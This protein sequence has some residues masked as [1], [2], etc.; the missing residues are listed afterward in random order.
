MFR[1]II[2]SVLL[3][4]ASVCFLHAQVNQEWVAT[5]GLNG[6][7][8]AVV[9]D[10]AGNIYVTGPLNQDLITNKYDPQGN[11][12]WTASHF[13]PLWSLLEPSNRHIMLDPEGHVYVSIGIAD[14]PTNYDYFT[15]KYNPDGTE[16]W[17]ARFVG[18][19]GGHDYP[20]SM[21]VD[22]NGNVYVTGRSMGNN[23][24]YATVKY[25]TSGNQLWVALYNGSYNHSDYAHDIV[26]DSN[27]DV[28]VTGSVAIASQFDQWA[29]IKYNSAGVEQWIE[30]KGHSGT[31]NSAMAMII[32]D[33]GDVCVTGYLYTPGINYATVK[34]DPDGNELWT[35]Y[36][37]YFGHGDYAF[38]IA[39][40][41]FGNIYVTGESCGFS[42]PDFYRN[43]IATV[44]YDA[45]GNQIWAARYVEPQMIYAKASPRGI[46][47]DN[48]GNV[49]V[50]G[51]NNGPWISD[52]ITLMYT[53]DGEERWRARC[54]DSGQNNAYSIAIDR[55]S[56]VYVAGRGQFGSN[57]L[58]Y[59][60]IKYNQDP[61]PSNRISPLSPPIVIPA[62]GGRFHYLLRVQNP[63]P[64]PTITSSW[65]RL[66]NST[67]NYM[68]VSTT[69]ART[70]PGNAAPSRIFTQAI[71]DTLPAGTYDFISYIGIYPEYIQDSSF[72]TI[73]KSA[74]SDGSPWVSESSCTGDFFDEFALQDNP[75]SIHNSS[76]ITHNCVPNPFNP[77]TTIRFDLPIAAQVTLEVF[78]INGRNVGAHGMRPSGGGGSAGARSAPLQETWYYVGSHEI[79][80]DGSG[81]PSGVYLYRLT[82]GEL[83]ANG[84]IVLLK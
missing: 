84:K 43:D 69:F 60:T 66:R 27:G 35:S 29:T 8:F 31:L 75:S 82:A 76:L 10:S 50:T 68:N 30:Y 64:T 70:L 72:F 7:A 21:A 48:F 63:N 42:T 47:T 62:N 32:D 67:G 45:A 41:R 81:L 83:T 57:L 51:R 55:N 19:A 53:T 4:C 15:I 74:L 28:Y 33:S 49:Y 9:T 36:Y 25:D 40:D 23:Y 73:T 22:N 18:P 16:A 80:F 38:Y 17:E 54:S 52:F 39:G 26:V 1:S 58:S 78:D 56:N 65:N 79:I 2:L 12:L 14:Y 13:G 3:L 11:L 20:N 46:V 77:T 5:D 59:L 34:Y 24:N 61:N 71:A 37:D 6:S 44:K